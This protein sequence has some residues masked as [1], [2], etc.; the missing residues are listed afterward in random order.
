M[1]DVEQRID[2]LEEKY[3]N[4]HTVVSVIASKVEAT[5]ENSVIG[6]AAMVWS[7]MSK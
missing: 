7:V 4:L 1:A 5:N 6:I 3:S 2:N